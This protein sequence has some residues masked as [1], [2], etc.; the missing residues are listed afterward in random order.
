MTYAFDTNIV[1]YLIRDDEYVAKRFEQEIIQGNHLYVIPPVAVFEIKRWLLEY[2]SQ[3]YQAL[4]ASFEALYRDVRGHALMRAPEWEKAAEI[5]LSLKQKGE[6]IEDADILIAA[7]CMVNDYVLVTNNLKH[8][9]RV[10]GLKLDN[11]KE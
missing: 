2:K 11:W 8:F 4:A 6:L 1:T 3:P 10:V 5:Y 9:C 7:Y